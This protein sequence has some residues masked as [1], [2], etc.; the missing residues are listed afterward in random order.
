MTFNPPLFLLTGLGWLCL[1]FLLGLLLLLTNIL[2]QPLPPVFRPIHVHA[3]LVGGVGQI[4]LGAMLAFTPALL[5]TG[6][7]RPTSHPV[8]YAAINLGALGMLIGFALGHSLIIG[9][10]GVL[11]VLAFFSLLGNVVRQARTSLV[12]APLNIWF[13]GVALLALLVGLGVGEAMSLQLFSH[14]TIGRARLAHIHLNLLGF[15]TLT[16]V[17]TMH[18]L[19]PTVLNGRLH[20]PLL[21]RMTFVILPLGIA[22]LIAGFL[23]GQLYVDIL[24]GAIFITGV[25]LYGYNILRTWLEAGRPRRTATDHLLLATFFLLL[26]V[27]TG[28]LVSINSL[29]YPPPIPFGTLHL[30][31]YTHLALVGFVLQTIMGALSH[32]LPITLAVSRTE[33]N[34]MREPY[35]SELNGLIEYG[36]PVQVG[37]LCLGTIGLALVASLV[38]QFNLGDWPVKLATW[39]AAGLLFVGFGLFAGKVSLLV[40]HRPSGAN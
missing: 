36:R 25:I 26:A 28:I 16:I 22:V 33:S 17:G 18:N 10:S 12:S 7:D 39:T 38:W 23:T 9:G 6:R 20:S 8:L 31:A 35:L 1:S 40:T 13:Y 11:V 21:A 3:A 30:V 29:S 4:I 34:K 32:L 15:V 24:A 19:F 27:I 14:E 5:L 37:A 2:G